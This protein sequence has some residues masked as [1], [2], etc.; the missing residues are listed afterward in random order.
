MTKLRELLSDESKWTQRTMARD[1]ENNC[2]PLAS[3]DACKFCL[4][5]ALDK[6]DISASEYNAKRAKIVD[7]IKNC[8][9]A[10]ILYASPAIGSMPAFYSLSKFNDFTSWETIDR[11]LD[12]LGV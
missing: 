3:K 11:M 1:A 8:P 9:G 6:L 4:V 10:D 2:V 7:Y 12:E 5:G